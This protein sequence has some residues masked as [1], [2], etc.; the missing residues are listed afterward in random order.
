MF[1]FSMLLCNIAK[2]NGP[3]A[4]LTVSANCVTISIQI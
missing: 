1:G 3:V 4:L 2:Q